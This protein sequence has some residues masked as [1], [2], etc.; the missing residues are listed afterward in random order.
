MAYK[1][2]SLAQ[3][4]FLTISH[5]T[6]PCSAF[7][8]HWP[9]FVCFAKPEGLCSCSF[10]CKES[11]PLDPY[12]TES[13]SSESHLR[14]YLFKETI[15]FHPALSFPLGSLFTFLCFIFFLAVTIIITAP[16]IY[17]FIIYCMPLNAHTLDC[18]IH[19]AGIL[20]RIP[21]ATFRAP[22]AGPQ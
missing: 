8:S 12:M 20:F 2:Y 14:W 21:I 11:F 4:T 7:P 1:I 19:R 18:T 6:L 10:L 3:S 5:T 9:L 13:L 17:L 16:I 15:L 22:V